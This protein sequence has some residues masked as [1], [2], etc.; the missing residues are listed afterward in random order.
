M[1]GAAEATERP[2]KEFPNPFFQQKLPHYYSNISPHAVI[3]CMFFVAVVFIPIGVAIILAS[4][5]VFQIDVRYDDLQKCTSSKH[6]SAQSFVVNGTTYSQGCTTNAQFTLKN[7]VVG[8]IYMYYRLDPFYQNYRLYAQ[9]MN[10][11]QLQGA[12]WSSSDLGY[13]TPYKEPKGGKTILVDGASRSYSD[14]VYSPCGAVAA[15]MFNDTISLWYAGP[16]ILPDGTILPN[17]LPPS[18]STPVCLGG[19]FTAQ[20][21]RLPNITTNCEKKGIAFSQDV[22]SRFSAKPQSSP[23]VWT[24]EGYSNTSD[25]YFANGWYANE[26][27]HKV[28]LIYDLDFMVWARIAPLSNFRKLY[29][30]ITQ[31]LQ[32]GTY[33]FRIDERF[34]ATSITAEKHIILATTSWVGGAN[35]VLGALYLTLGSLALV[36]AFGF[37]GMYMARSKP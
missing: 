14:M 8:P 33:F 6:S 32:A 21:D 36:L 4:D 25:P 19:A 11:N 15:S 28:P 29:R 18:G 17:Q 24:G 1:T 26:V 7:A 13:C 31:D 22:D 37:V 30:K 35:Q 27:G 23:S 9:S 5:S 20:G 2:E 10:E 34:D 12:S 3:G 16:S